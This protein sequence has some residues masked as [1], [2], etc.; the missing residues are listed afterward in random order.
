MTIEQHIGMLN[1][2]LNVMSIYKSQNNV[3]S[4]KQNKKENI[5][6]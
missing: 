1:F 3:F 2:M 5:Y 4:I 6:I